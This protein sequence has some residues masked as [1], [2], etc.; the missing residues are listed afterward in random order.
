MQIH[1]KDHFL[2]HAMKTDYK[3]FLNLILN[4]A[5]C[6]SSSNHTQATKPAERLLSNQQ[7]DDHYLEMSDEIIA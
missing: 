3:A 6:I 7:A 1:V 5:Q 4:I 2:S